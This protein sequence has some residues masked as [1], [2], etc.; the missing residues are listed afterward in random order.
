MLEK[1]FRTS[2]IDRKCFEKD[3]IF[4]F[5][6]IIENPTRSSRIDSG[7]EKWRKCSEHYSGN[8]NIFVLHE[9]ILSRSPNRN[10]KTEEKDTKIPLHND[11]GIF[12]L[13]HDGILFEI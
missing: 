11:R 12:R 13:I 10:N 7:C 5:F 1:R 9:T 6:E 4:A 8:D 3:L 2:L